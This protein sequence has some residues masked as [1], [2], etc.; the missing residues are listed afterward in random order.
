M[1]RGMSPKW[2][3]NGN[4]RSMSAQ[5]RM[6]ARKRKRGAEPTVLELD[7][8]VDAPTAEA[9]AATAAGAAVPAVAPDAAA[10]SI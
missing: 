6:S 4:L 1:Y 2:D 5:R 10:E 9:T 3:A 7:A 8:D